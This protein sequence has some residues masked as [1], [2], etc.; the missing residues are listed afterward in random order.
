MIKV[1]LM[2]FLIAHVLGDFYFQSDNLAKAKL[3]SFPDLLKHSIIYL[4]SFLF[5]IIP[6]F[7]INILK[8]ALINAVAHF[9]LDLAKAYIKRKICKKANFDEAKSDL[10]S[11]II[12]QLSHVL[13]IILTVILIGIRSEPVIFINVLQDLLNRGSID[14]LN[15]ISWI[16]LILLIMRPASITIVKVSNRFKPVNNEEHEGHPNAGA[17]IGILERFIIILLLSV[18]QYAAIGFVLTAKSIA[19]Y[20]KIIEDPIFSEH[21]LL[22]TLQ[23]VLFAIIPYMLIF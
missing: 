5:L 20:N 14:F 17:F 22:G 15:A 4:L 3:E 12:D 13:V 2:L 11:Y 1:V 7:S 18:K 9:F 19:R 21:Y 23:S 10:R 6:V 16:L 8:W